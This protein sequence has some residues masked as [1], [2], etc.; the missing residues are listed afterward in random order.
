VIRKAFGKRLTELPAHDELR[1]PKTRLQEW[2]QARASGLP[3]YELI[4][5]SGKAHR[6][7]FEVRCSIQDGRLQST[8][9][10][11]SRRNAEQE[12]AEKMLV[13]LGTEGAD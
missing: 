12:S 10:G 8:G 2:L 9:R 6:Q 3:A 4:K 11:T 1:D 7:M 5:T 13:I